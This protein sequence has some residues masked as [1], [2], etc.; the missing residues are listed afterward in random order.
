MHYR[1][2]NAYTTE[3]STEPTSG[4]IWAVH[5][6]EHVRKGNALNRTEYYV[7]T[8]IHER[9]AGTAVYLTYVP[10]VDMTPEC[11]RG[12]ERGKWVAPDLEAARRTVEGIYREA[13]TGKSGRRHIIHEDGERA[14]CYMPSEAGDFSQLKPQSPA[15]GSTSSL[16]A[17]PM[18]DTA[19]W[20]ST[21]KPTPRAA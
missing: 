10:S 7:V 19:A 17:E 1:A 20:V 4:D 9:K 18:A 21:F 8:G 12:Y 15:G 2:V 16:V 14:Y 5:T 11:G 6:T 13:P 3:P